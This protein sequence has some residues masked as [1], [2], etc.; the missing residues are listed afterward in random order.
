MK[1]EEFLYHNV[2][3]KFKYLVIYD[4]YFGL[5]HII[6]DIIIKIL[7]LFTALL[8]FFPCKVFVLQF[9]FF[10]SLLNYFN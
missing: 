6:N 1:N 9:F 8:I 10:L 5:K 3:L 7:N 2:V 4:D